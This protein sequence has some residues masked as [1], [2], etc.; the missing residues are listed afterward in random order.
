MRHEQRARDVRMSASPP[1]SSRFKRDSVI[2]TVSII[3]KH[4]SHVLLSS[5]SDCLKPAQPKR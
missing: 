4:E 1:E 3:K 2:L 5:T